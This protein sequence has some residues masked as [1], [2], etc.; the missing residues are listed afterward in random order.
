M[1]VSQ[2]RVS[3]YMK[4]DREAKLL[5]DQFNKRGLQFTFPF[6]GLSLM[7]AYGYL[8]G[9]RFY[10]HLRNGDASLCV[11]VYDKATEIKRLCG[12][13]VTLP[14]V[15]ALPVVEIPKETDPDLFPSIVLLV[16]HL[17]SRRE[18][19]VDVFSALIENLKPV[20]VSQN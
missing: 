7:Q 19:L 6:E 13:N 1:S 11:G 12:Q 5:E 9:K 16:S 18:R 8:D 15:E 3:T 14:T 20:E 17:E 2:V 10:F 4:W